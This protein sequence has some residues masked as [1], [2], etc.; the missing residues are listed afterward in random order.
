MGDRANLVVETQPKKYVYLYTHWGGEDIPK[1]LQNG[2]RLHQRWDDPSY[3]AR[4]LFREM[5]AGGDGEC[6][7]GIDTEMGANNRP[8]LLVRP[9]DGRKAGKVELY[10]DDD[11][12]SGVCGAPSKK[13]TFKQFCD[14]QR[15][16]WRKL[17]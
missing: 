12:D 4:I 11:G 15:I 6:G 1:T 16:S 8:I 9:E 17:L 7:F 2:L 14:I 3:L 13:W 5:G 10:S